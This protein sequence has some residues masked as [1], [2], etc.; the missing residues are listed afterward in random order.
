MS[1]K[2]KSSLH[3]INN[4][5]STPLRL[6]TGGMLAT[7]VVGGGVA[8]AAHKNITLDVNGEII[9]ASS[10]TGNVG[11]ILEKNGVEVNPKDL[12]SPAPSE[13]VSN[14]D[15]IKVRSAK[16]VALIIDGKREN[17]D[18]TSVTVEEMLRQVDR[19]SVV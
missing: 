7:L 5:N 19:K 15:T 4:T 8:A 2:K 17:V 3:R 18:T 1:P 9:E 11:D 10:V 16:Q 6:A 13:S 14:N 12:V